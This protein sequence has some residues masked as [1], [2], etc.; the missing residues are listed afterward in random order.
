MKAR[1]LI[2][3]SGTKIFLGKNSENNDE[4]VDEYAGKKNT[5]LHTAKPGSPFCIIDKINPTKEE[6]KLS[7]IVC[8]SKSQD[9]RDNKNDV[10]VNVFTGKDVYK[11]KSMKTGTWGLKKKPKLVK[12]KKIEIED[13]EDKLKEIN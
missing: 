3:N 13:W 5:I 4:L 9:W 2:L 12:V 8:A 10:L 6:I 7:A 11:E 1:E